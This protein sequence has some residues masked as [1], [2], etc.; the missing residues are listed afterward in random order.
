[1]SMDKCPLK[2]RDKGD[3]NPPMEKA[4]PNQRVNFV[5][6]N[7][8]RRAAE[9]GLS[10][11]AVSRGAGLHKSYLRKTMERNGTPK[12]ETLTKI[13]EVLQTTVL[14]LRDD[15]APLRARRLAATPPTVA[16]PSADDLPGR[17]GLPPATGPVPGPVLRGDARLAE[18]DH[19]A[20]SMPKD[21]P[22]YGTA[23]GSH[24]RGAF[25]FAG[26]IVEYVRR[27][28]ALIGTSTA[29]AFYVEGTSMAPEHNP[30][31]LRFATAVRPPR[32]GDSV[33]VQLR[34]EKDGDIEAVIGH[35]VKRTGTA[36]HIGKLNPSATV[37]FKLDYVV[38]V[39]KVLT[40][41]ELF[42]V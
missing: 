8:E 28:P 38:A 7:I 35:L 42:G 5:L 15:L 21:L 2:Q 33:V 11:E 17:S 13:A 29:Y 4:E 18:V 30:G 22:V 32:Y 6:S 25:Q 1:M 12:V 3:D 14:A 16:E 41:N 37:E 23:A 24:L 27:P 36:L 10:L 9:L 39:H 26:G 34:T 19:L 20:T 40:T 31:D